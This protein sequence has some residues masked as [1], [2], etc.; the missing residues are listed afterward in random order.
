MPLDARSPL[1]NDEERLLQS[2]LRVFGNASDPPDR[3]QHLV[4]DRPDQRVITRLFSVQ[5]GYLG[6]DV[7]N[8][9]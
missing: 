6:V 8:R 4:F 2:I 1:P 5:I 7:R 3:P 9:H